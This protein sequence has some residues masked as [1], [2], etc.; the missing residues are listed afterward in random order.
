MK[1]SVNWIRKI[2]EQD[3]VS[4]DPMPDGID[5]L[6]EKIGA[7]LG[8]VEEVIDVG[9]KYQGIVVAK[10]ISCEKHPNADKLSVC[11]IDDAK[12]VKGVRRDA[13]GLVQVVCGA[14]NVAAD[15]LVAWIPPGVAV[16]STVDKEPFVLEA[17]NIRGVISSGMIASLKELALGEDHTGILVIDQPTKAGQPFAEVYKLDDFIID[18]ENKMFTHRPDL[19]GQLGIVRELAGIQ[20]HVFKSPDWY[21]ENPQLPKPNGVATHKLSVKND[22]PQLVSRFT[23]VV[24]KDVK[25]GSS[26]LWLKVR[27]SNVGVKSVNNIVDITNFLMLE[28]AQPLHAYDY[29]KLLMQ[30]SQEPRAK[31]QEVTIGV[32][33]AEAGEE[34]TVLGGKRLKLNKND[35]VIT[36]ADKPIG[37]GGIMGGADTEVNEA[38]T[39]IALEVG[40]FDMNT[41]RTSA[42]RH[43]LFTEAATRFTKNQSSR[44]NLAVAVK[45]ID[46]IKRLAGGR[47]A[48]PIIDDRHFHVKAVTVNVIPQFINE[49]LGLD[50]STARIKKLLENVEFKVE[51]SG[52]TLKIEA[53]FWRTDI[54]IPEDI[55]EEVGRLYGYEHLPLALPGKDLTPAAKNETLDFKQR[56]RDI[57]S[58]AGANEA[59]TYSF[60]H[61]SL[62]EKAG[63]D[64][65]DA[66]HIRNALSPD[67]QYY[68]L[69]LAP[70]L[71]E[72]VHPNI[73]EG[74]EDLS[75]F[76]IGRAHVR[77]VVDEEK[78]PM[79]L[80]R[81]CLVVAK[82]RS[83]KEAGAPY[84]AAKKQLENL[85]HSVGIHSMVYEPLSKD[86]P[87]Q[88]QA[89]AS[90]YEPKRTAVIYPNYH[91]K[92][93]IGLIG[94]PSQ[95]LKQS[96]KLPTFI[97]GAELD[98]EVLI[99]NAKPLDY[100]PLNKFPAIEQD[101]CLRSSNNLSYGELTNFVL[102]TLGKIADEHGFFHWLSPVDIYQKPNDKAHKQT[103]WHIG[104][105]HPKKTLTTAEAN[106]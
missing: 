15:Q 68:R 60:I 72:K 18:I 45:A 47:Q 4:A 31:S 21:K 76:E 27:L 34:L 103:T 49:R 87:M 79:E 90:A 98:I 25:V 23:V 99:K 80:E 66:Y 9:K 35:I 26:P 74:F 84:F 42:M 51:T 20:Q 52:E 29:D 8:A 1:V 63:Q 55:V 11:L 40:N 77:G 32:R 70:S 12:A 46:E 93:V 22:T 73:K 5:A 88:W 36:S 75:L 67:L 54:E 104:L 2:I 83:R 62:I 95:A 101:I 6:V 24:L 82:N 57:L 16:P 13:K 28:T 85:L 30:Q 3:H 59:L 39:N 50:L 41:I 44:Q 19:F 86:L 43:G 53:P 91:K 94:E 65:K 56:A 106:K 78:L 89:A 96:L 71:L 38:T 102:G 10:V 81:L 14:P 105:S 33:L 61:S 7:Q 17:R 48:S 69:S 58:A 92:E 97:A 64:V 100:Y 37:L